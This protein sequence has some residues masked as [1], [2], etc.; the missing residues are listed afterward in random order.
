MIARPPPARPRRRWKRASCMLLATLATGALAVELA[1]R[2]TPLPPSLWEEEPATTILLDYGG[3]DLAALGSAATRSC[4]PVSL[5]S[6]SPSLIEATLAAED[7]RF[8]N[9]RGVDWTAT[10]GA[11]ITNL[12]AQRVISGASTIT[13]QLIKLHTGPTRRTWRTKLRESLGALRLE[14]EFSKN[15]ILEK[16]LNRIDYGDR[17]RGIEAA[18]RG[19]F[20][21]PA[22]DL[23]TNEAVFLAGLP[24][25]PSRLNPRIHPD[26][27]ARRFHQVASR[28]Q[29][30]GWMS[31]EELAL[32][33][34]PQIVPEPAIPPNAPHFVAALR[35]RREPLPGSLHATLDL[36]LQHQVEEVIQRHLRRLAPF[37][38]EQAAALVMDH[39]DGAIRAWVGSGNWSARDGQIDGVVLPRSS[40]S[41][42]KPFL[43]LRAI[44]RQL[45]TAASLLPDT[46][47][48]IRSAYPDYDPRNYDDRYWGPV[49][50]REALANS[51]NVPAV[52]ALAK[53]GARDATDYLHRCGISL[54]RSLDVYGAG[55]ILGN[56]EVRMLDLAAAYGALGNRGISAVPRFLAADPVVHRA[57]AS[58][59]A[60]AIVADILSDDEARRKTFGP[61]SPLS[62][63]NLRIPCK[64]GTSSGFRDAWTIGVTGRHVVAV[65]IGNFSGHPMNEVAS[66]TG[67]APA[68]RDIVDLLLEHDGGVPPPGPDL[69]RVPVCSLTGFLP[70]PDSPASVT[71]FFLPGTAPV[72]DARHFFSRS[73][74]RSTLLL[75]PEYAVWCRSSHNYLDAAVQPSHPLQIAHPKPNARFLI[76]P[77]LPTHRQKI[78]FIAIAS[79]HS[80][81]TWEIDGSP[82]PAHPSSPTSAFWQLAPGHHH[83]VARQGIARA[84]ISFCVE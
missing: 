34:P 7:H 65:W 64:T 79:P 36:P 78:E 30:L 11:A 37:H 3:R 44:D 75:P 22:S 14:R 29:R 63:E 4:R 17:R 6:V 49:R 8:H 73:N 66:V 5:E 38:A 77:H 41:T 69:H 51:L 50:V 81:I 45:L 18:A 9:H 28:L 31:G 60:A 43:Y 47:D 2:L 39:R 68:W 20:G 62:F 71:E 32:Q 70:A 10:L 57:L 16:Y 21:K 19:F 84:E 15:T 12:R 27:A 80:P 53:V 55:L 83:L 46:P 74:G 24:Q 26:R 59:Q 13:Q 61:F 1:I 35:A 33:A 54:A 82:L 76:D 23:S 42:L 25:A 48:A 52:V 58:P 72:A 67:P 40:G 56:A